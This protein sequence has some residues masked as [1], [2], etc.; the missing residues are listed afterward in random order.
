MNVLNAILSIFLGFLVSNSY[1]FISFGSILFFVSISIWFA[2]NYHIK[3]RGFLPYTLCW[4][5]FGFAFILSSLSWMIDYIGIYYFEIKYYLIWIFLVVI[6]SLPY[7]LIPILS[8]NS[9]EK[10]NIILIP[11]LMSGI[12]ISREYT[13]DLPTPSLMPSYLFT[14]LIPSELYEVWGGSGVSL[15]LYIFSYTFASILAVKNSISL[16]ISFFIVI[17][18]SIFT[19]F[20]HDK[21]RYIDEIS[22]RV[23]N[24]NYKFNHNSD[25]NTYVE[26][27]NSYAK[28]SQIEPLTDVTI[29]PES[30]SYID[31]NN[32]YLE[33]VYDLKKSIKIDSEV[34]IGM[35]TQFD[36][37]ISNS[38]LSLSKNE[39]IYNKRFLIPFEEYAP[40]WFTY[41]FSMSEKENPHETIRGKE[42]GFVHIGQYKGILSICYEALFSRAYIAKEYKYDFIVIISDFNWSNK[43]WLEDIMFKIATVR[44]MEMKKPVLLS[45]NGGISSIISDEGDTK[46]V[47]NNELVYLDGKIKIGRG[48]SFYNNHGNK[49]NII[50]IF[51]SIA[52][53]FIYLF[54]GKCLYEN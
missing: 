33:S 28:I 2:F 41:L 14:D 5:L 20:F 8:Y 32:T 39:V 11:S 6:L 17:Y 34:L 37:G 3:S 43:S 19:L 35:K 42:L 31:L 13:T 16:K 27:V 23:I 51:I 45:S 54:R 26:R 25:I 1:S 4:F 46:T 29:W 49:Y 53:S 22:V 21:T 30:S 36:N 24:D 15:I 12:E 40:K 50:M 44:A 9:Y 47:N 52:I 38:I 10:F 18:F 7:L 48:E